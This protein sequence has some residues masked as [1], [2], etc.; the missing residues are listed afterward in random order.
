MPKNDQ[1]LYKTPFSSDYWKDALRSFRDLRGM[2]FAALMIA[3]C[4]ILSKFSIPVL[5]GLKITFGY[6]ARALCALVYGPIGVVVFAAAEDTMSFL[7]SNKGAVY[8]PGYMLTTAIGCFIYALF[9]YR[10]RI[11]LSRIFFAKLLTNLLNIF[12]GSLWSAILYGKGYLYYM[13]ASAVKNTVMLIPQVILLLLLFQ[14]LLPILQRMGLIPRQVDGPIMGEK[15]VQKAILLAVQ[16]LLLLVA[17]VVVLLVLR[18]MGL[19]DG[20]IP[21]VKWGCHF[22]ENC[23]K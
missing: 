17:F 4:I 20:S 14:A 15:P 11:T 22:V 21:F 10:A 19:W 3:M 9:F 6:L 1:T 7:L 13:S 8:F 16:V 18:N 5:D 23:L 12:L 2:M